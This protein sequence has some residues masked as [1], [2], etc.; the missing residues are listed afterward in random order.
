VVGSTFLNGYALIGE[1]TNG[2]A[3][4]DA[5]NGDAFFGD[6]TATN[7]IAVNASGYVG[8][9]T[10]SPNRLLEVGSG[11]P[12]SVDA[13]NIRLTALGALAAADSNG[14]AVV[15]NMTDG[16][17][18]NAGEI[19]G[20][21]YASE[22]FIPLHIN[23]S[24]IIL[25]D[26][27][28][29]NGNVGIGTASPGYKL[30]VVGQIHVSNGI[31]FPDGN[32]QTTAFNTTLCGGDYAESVNVSGDRTSYEP[33]DV[34]VI[35]ADSAT[36]VS[37]STEPYSPLVA[38]IYSTKPGIIGRRQASDQA[39]NKTEIP[40][41]MVGIVPTKVS[42]ENGPIKRGDLLV[43]SATPGYA[44]KGT[45]RGRMLGAVLGKAMGNL[46]SGTGVIELLVS[47]Q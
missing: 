14:K 47:L 42:A 37:K 39:K 35:G 4:I 33:G 8:I 1:G 32:T 19:L 2:T 38:G 9:G 44:M 6:N 30:D 26:P 45:D 31:V 17:F 41:A 5:Y 29:G 18:S 10:T 25:G 15:L 40:M 21:D 13:T 43:S 28:R 36:D 12:S 24:E 16:P 27:S 46:D 11:I 20:E 7:G 3:V 23:G 22:T 34:L